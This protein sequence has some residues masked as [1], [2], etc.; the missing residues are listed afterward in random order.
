MRVNEDEKVIFL[1]LHDDVLARI[2]DRARVLGMSRVGWVRQL[3]LRALS[4]D[5]DG[6]PVQVEEPSPGG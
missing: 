1:K 5:V 3:V 2:D 6:N 4:V